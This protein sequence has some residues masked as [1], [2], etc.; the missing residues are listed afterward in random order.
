[1]N[2]TKRLENAIN[3]LYLA[4]HNDKLNPECSK[5][6]AVGNICNNTDSWKY[7]SDTHGSL[8]LNYVGR[9][10]QNLGRK[11]YGYSPEE[12]L[13]IEAAFLSGCGYTLPFNQKTKKPANP[14]SKETLFTGLCAVVEFLCKLDGISNVMD[15]S[16]LFEY[17]TNRSAIE[18]KQPMF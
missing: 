12:L 11:F 13:N 3:K 10:H 9:V 17:K 7:F 2:T 6:C 8:I 18:N 16:N 15:Y 5:Q 4:F 1:M 14:T